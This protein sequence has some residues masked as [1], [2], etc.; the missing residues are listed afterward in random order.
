M[1]LSTFLRGDSGLADVVQ[2]YPGNS[3]LDILASGE[4][5][6]NASVLLTSEA[7]RAGLRE[8][9]LSYD[10]VILDCPPVLP[11]ADAVIAGN[12]VDG[13]VV[14]V[15]AE[16]TRRSDLADTLSQLSNGGAKVVGVVINV[17]ASSWSG[18]GYRQGYYASDDSVSLS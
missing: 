9:G 1:G 2:A 12:S 10:R 5:P 14:V 13:V 7:F 18:Y 15:R 17:V 11:V 3:K 4:V 6:P 16:D 8:F